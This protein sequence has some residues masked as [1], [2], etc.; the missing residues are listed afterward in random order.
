MSGSSPSLLWFD[1]RD[2]AHDLIRV[3]ADY[4]GKDEKFYDVQTTI[5]VLNIGNKWLMTPQCSGDSRLSQTCLLSPFGQQLSKS[6]M[7]L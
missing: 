3:K 2:L 6:P 7:A 1:R 5:A 4:L